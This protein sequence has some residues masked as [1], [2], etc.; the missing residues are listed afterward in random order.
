MGA[1][2]TRSLASRLAAVLGVAD[3]GHETSSTQRARQMYGEGGADTDRAL[4]GQASSV[5]IDHTADDGA[6]TDTA[7]FR[8][9]DSS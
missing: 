8:K 9:W 3:V 1:S 7:D 2:V 4:D 6:A 5:E